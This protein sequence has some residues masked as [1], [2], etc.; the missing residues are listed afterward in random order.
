MSC[1]GWILEELFDDPFAALLAVSGSFE[2][3]WTSEDWDLFGG[4]LAA[5]LAV[6]GFLGA[7][8]DALLLAGHGFCDAA[9]FALCCCC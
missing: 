2:G 6:Y 7:P 9:P 8:G 4:L 3:A 1:G 5:L